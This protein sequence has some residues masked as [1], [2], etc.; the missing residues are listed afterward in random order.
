MTNWVDI[1][2]SPN[3]VWNN[4]EINHKPFQHIETLTNGQKSTYC[5]FLPLD[6]ESE[7]RNENDPYFSFEKVFQWM[8]KWIHSYSKWEIWENKWWAFWP[9]LHSRVNQIWHTQVSFQ[10]DFK[11][12]IILYFIRTCAYI[13][14][15]DLFQPILRNLIP[16]LRQ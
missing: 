16:N 2:A 7:N 15:W 3:L 9:Y 12:Y 13:S 6:I 1:W 11:M 8:S 14:N 5:L 4:D 10:I